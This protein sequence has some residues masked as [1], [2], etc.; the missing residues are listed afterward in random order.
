MNVRPDRMRAI[1]SIVGAAF[2]DAL[3]WPH[4]ERARAIR[5]NRSRLALTSWQKRSGGRFQAY[6]EDIEAGSYSDDTQLILAVARSRLSQTA[7]WETFTQIEL[8]FWTLYERGGGGATLRAARLHLQ[9]VLP[10]EASKSDQ[11]KY[12]GAGGNGVAMRIAPHVLRDVGRADF[13]VI[14]KSVMADGASTHGHPRA[15]VGALAYAY[16]LWV[17]FESKG[18]FEFGRL[19]QA[20]RDGVQ[21]W[22][23]VP[24]I[25]TIWPTWWPAAVRTEAYETVWNA[26]VGELLVALDIVD[27]GLSAGALANDE[28]V[29]GH[30]G[31]FDRRTNGAGTVAASAA[32][33]L[34]SKH[35]A[36]PFEGVARAALAHGADT[37]TIA[38]MTGG[39]VGA[40]SGL[41]WLGTQVG[42]L[43]DL[44]Y[45]E[46]IALDLLRRSD[47]G[48]LPG[49]VVPFGAAEAKSFLLSLRSGAR[50]L[51]LPN[52]QTAQV[53]PHG[54]V[55][56]V[57]RNIQASAWAAKTSDGQS[58]VFKK[59]EKI[60]ESRPKSRPPIQDQKNLPLPS[61]VVGQFAAVTVYVSDL[62]RSRKLFEEFFG[63]CP[64]GSTSKLV[65][66]GDSFAL[67]QA[68]GDERVGTAALY[69]G[70]NDV[71]GCHRNLLEWGNLPV[72]GITQKSG[73][74]AFACL[75]YDGHRLEIF[76]E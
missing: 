75:D 62:S 3:G 1:G 8:P 11:A 60:P 64:T 16:A 33:F 41:D 2:G 28:E 14:A 7:W 56:P 49:E 36:S 59:V 27:G 71:A 37:D 13:D 72:S 63:L 48:P 54:G 19:T 29:L 73:R 55:R 51:T 52:G 42:Q 57:G 6:E 69:L 50:S 65:Q 25:S 61:R 34:A 32:I 10:W 70:V 15:L 21:V 20:V 31:C 38:S 23:P 5:D 68:E 53:E 40:I 24:D 47:A 35:A 45:L 30:L 74:V 67:R 58:F 43:Q 12:F 22:A 76:Q 66:F 39:L 18:T 4:E 9:G 17:A 46:T 44:A 26:A